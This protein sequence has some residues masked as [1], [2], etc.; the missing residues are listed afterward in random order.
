MNL[1][2]PGPIGVFDSSVNSVQQLQAILRAAAPVPGGVLLGT[3]PDNASLIT[4]QTFADI[5]IQLA[6]T[7]QGFDIIQIESPPVAY[8]SAVDA[9]F[10][11]RNGLAGVTTYDAASSGAILQGG[12]DSLLGG[13][14]LDAYYFFDYAIRFNTNIADA[15]SGGVGRLKI[16]EGGV[17]LPTD[18]VFLRYSYIDNVSYGSESAG[19]NRFVAGFEKVFANGLYS[20]ELRAPLATDSISSSTLDADRFSST[21]DARFGNLTMYAKALLIN[22]AQFALSGGLGLALPTAE[23]TNV[24]YVNGT[25]LLRIENESVHVQPFL[26]ML[27][28]PTSRLFAQAFVQYDATASGNTIMLDAT[29]AGL[30]RVGTL[31]DANQLF[32]DAAVGYWVYKSDARSGLTGVVPML[33]IHQNTAVQNGDVIASGPF[34]IGNFDGNSSFTSLTVGTTIEFAKRS[35]CTIGYSAAVGGGQDR[36]M[37]G[38][39]QVLLN[40]N[41]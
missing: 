20:F 1:S 3:V 27:Y 13:Q 30:S 32:V 24:N 12:V 8:S 2:E 39:L 40:R 14:D 23:G 17:V 5:Q 34:Q 9:I 29:G 36:M 25:P 6:G 4:Q 16:S 7:P 31:T 35:Q 33:E 21:N 10:Q 15:T 26:G 19:L 22:R 11:T 18:R 38:T 37:D 28:T 41:F